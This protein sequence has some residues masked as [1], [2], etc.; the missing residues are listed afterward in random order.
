VS[1]LLRNGIVPCD[2]YLFKLRGK[3]VKASHEVASVGGI[4][5]DA[6]RFLPGLRRLPAGDI[7]RE[8]RHSN[9]DDNHSF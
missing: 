7:T 6:E 5:S 1:S 8:L 9:A 3:S 4:E 2:V